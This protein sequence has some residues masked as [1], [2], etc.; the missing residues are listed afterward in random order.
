MQLLTRRIGGRHKVKNSVWGMLSLRCILGRQMNM[1]S[2]QLKIE[3]LILEETS[4]RE[5]EVNHQCLKAI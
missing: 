2:N 3:A 1:Y 4:K 5:K